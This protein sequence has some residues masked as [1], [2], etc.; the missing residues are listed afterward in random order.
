[1]AG[2]LP[3]TPWRWPKL[4]EKLIE[5]P[6]ALTRYLNKHLGD[7]LTPYIEATQPLP[8]V[9]VQQPPF[10]VKGN[11]TD[12]TAR[13]L[14]AAQAAA[15]WRGVLYMP[16]PETWYKMTAPFQIDWPFT[17]KGDG[18]TSQI[19][20][21]GCPAYE[22]SV[23][24]Q[25]IDN[26][27]FFSLDAAGAV[28]D[29]QADDG[30]AFLGTNPAKLFNNRLDRLFVRGFKNGLN[31]QYTWDSFFSRLHV[32]NCQNGFQTFGQSCN[33][34]LTQSRIYGGQRGLS[35][36]RD[37][38]IGGEG[39]ICANN[40]LISG[41]I[42]AFAEGFVLLVLSGNT[43]DL[44]NQAVWISN[45]TGAIVGCWLYA[46]QEAIIFGDLSAPSS[47]KWSIAGNPSIWSVS[48]TALRI[49]ALN[50]NISATGNHF[51]S[52]TKLLDMAG[53]ASDNIIEGNH[54]HGAGTFTGNP[55]TNTIR[56]NRG[57]ITEKAGAAV[58]G[59][60]VTSIVVN[61][62]LSFTPNPEDITVTP[63]NNLGA[64]TKFWFDTV[65]ATQ[66]TIRVDA[67]PGAPTATFAWKAAIL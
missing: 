29:P 15:D 41:A 59:A 23:D 37:G 43:H 45:G 63:T 67:A 17:L 49:G 65:T 7:G 5:D 57:C 64:A 9:N 39:L 66:F 24:D 8:I 30:V 33:N 31:L 52:D 44:C 16:R 62:G 55:H 14:D 4:D 47:G 12:E 19:R 13:I 56:N 40:P 2:V 46:E 20:F 21:F 22:A 61:H 34:V 3:V 51:V 53:D 54:F 10:R 60:A 50:R 1:M 25:I 11:G 36:V 58:I 18:L 48:G 28:V 35:L 27:F 38:A 26:I 6:A 42:G 32:L